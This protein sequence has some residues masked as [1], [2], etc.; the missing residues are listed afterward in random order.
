[1][2]NILQYFPYLR[3]QQ[4]HT[5]FKNV[6][7]CNWFVTKPFQCI[8]N[9]HTRDAHMQVINNNIFFSNPIHFCCPCIFQCCLQVFPILLRAPVNA[10]SSLLFLLRQISCRQIINFNNSRNSSHLSRRWHLRRIQIDNGRCLPGVATYLSGNNAKRFIASGG[11][12]G[13][14]DS[15]WA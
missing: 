13:S 2:K 4:R 6:L 10:L 7:S 5:R 3:I 15:G 14:C 11:S 9:S 12:C 1:M 8:P